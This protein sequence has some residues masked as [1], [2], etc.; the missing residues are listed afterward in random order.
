MDVGKA[1]KDV[2]AEQERSIRWLGLKCGVSSQ[3]MHEKLKSN[4]NMRVDSAFEIAKVLGVDVGDLVRA[5]S[6]IKKV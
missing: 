3:A 4:H 1:V 6:K 2:L 5:G